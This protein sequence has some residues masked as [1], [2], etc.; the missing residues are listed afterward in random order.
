MLH[1]GRRAIFRSTSEQPRRQYVSTAAGRA[2]SIL[3]AAQTS[4]PCTLVYTW[5][6]ASLAAL[7]YC[8]RHVHTVLQQ[9]AAVH[10]SVAA[11]GQYQHVYRH[12]SSTGS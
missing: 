4:V 12:V 3:S 6:A 1:L 5:Q 8:L 7:S 9:Q 10:H 2:W 11:E